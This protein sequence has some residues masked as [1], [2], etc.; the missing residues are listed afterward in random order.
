MEVTE[1]ISIT[2]SFLNFLIGKIGLIVSFLILF[3]YLSGL[4]RVYLK[5]REILDLKSRI[6]SLEETLGKRVS[7]FLVNQAQ[8]ERM[9]EKERKPL[10][11][12][13][14]TLQMER[15]FIL[16]KIPFVGIFKK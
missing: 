13:L 4:L 2:R 12:R 6:D 7:G 15:Q 11:A 16:E 9:V 3:W 5:E 1:I 14:E 10:I 8:L